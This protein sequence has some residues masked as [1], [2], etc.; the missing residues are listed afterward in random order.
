MDNFGGNVAKLVVLKYTILTIQIKNYMFRRCM[1]PEVQQYLV[2]FDD[3]STLTYRAKEQ[4]FIRDPIIR[5]CR[6]R[7]KERTD[8]ENSG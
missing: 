3:Y 5:C 2:T 6:S 8:G 4:A 1:E 7:R